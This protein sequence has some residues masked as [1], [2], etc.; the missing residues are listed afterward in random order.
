MFVDESK[1]KLNGGGWVLI[2]IAVF[3]IVL[4]VLEVFGV[5][6]GSKMFE[7]FGSWIPALES[8]A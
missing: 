4:A 1:K 5:P 2:I 6:A 7:W 8:G 3:F